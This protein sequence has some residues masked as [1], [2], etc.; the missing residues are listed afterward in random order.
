MTI[1]DDS[2]NYNVPS[3]VPSKDINP[4]KRPATSSAEVTSEYKILKAEFDRVIAFSQIQQAMYYELKSDFAQ[5]SCQFQEATQQAQT[6]PA[7][8]VL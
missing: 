5:L 8:R 7:Q 1:S 6:G 2:E 3:H 4:A